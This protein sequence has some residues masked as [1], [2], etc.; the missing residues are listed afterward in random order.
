MSDPIADFLT[1]IRNAQMAKMPV[2]SCPSSKIKIALSK[3][4]EQE[5]Y[6]NG[7]TVDEQTG[8]PIISVDLKYYGG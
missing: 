7:Y 5:G 8:K 1:R 2:V 6:I 4:L 3:V